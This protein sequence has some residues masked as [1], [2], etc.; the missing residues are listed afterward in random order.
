[1]SGWHK[2]LEKGKPF[3][4]LHLASS[5]DRSYLVIMAKL[6]WQSGNGYLCPSYFHRRDTMHY[7]NASEEQGRI[8]W[9][10]AGNTF[11]FEIAKVRGWC[12]GVWYE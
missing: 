2:F 12:L 6:S 7:K 5:N 3:V 11:P 9:M 10:H 4:V 8:M 1:M